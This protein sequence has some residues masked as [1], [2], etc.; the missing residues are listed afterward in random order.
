MTNDLRLQAVARGQ[1]G[2]F[3]REQAHDLGIPDHVLRGWVTSGLLDRFGVRTLRSSTSPTSPADDAA[4]YLLD[5]RPK[6][7]L[8]HQTAASL[9]GFDGYELE[10]PYHVTLRRGTLTSRPGLRVHT[11]QEMSL[12]DRVFID[13]MPVSSPVRTIIDLAP[14][15][16]PKH[17]TRIIDDAL[18]DR[19]IT[20]EGLLGRIADLRSQGRYGVPKLLEVIE[21]SEASRGGHSWLERRFLELVAAARLPKPEVQRHLGRV[22]GRLVR[23]DCYYPDVDLVIEFLGYRWHRSRSQSTRDA[24]RLNRLQMDGRMALQFT[25]DQVTSDPAGVIATVREARARRLCKEVQPEPAGSGPT[26]FT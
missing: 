5:I 19:L 7:W 14:T 6:A 12:V 17:L 25:Y 23:V 20:E 24:Q 9:H 22:D 16:S 11:S 13:G 18:R 10:L 15:T 3:L 21:G 1:H 26:A 4:A 2:A 8:S